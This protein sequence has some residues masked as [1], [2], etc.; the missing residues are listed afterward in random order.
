MLVPFLVPWLPWAKDY[1]PRSQQDCPHATPLFEHSTDALR[2]LHGNHGCFLPKYNWGSRMHCP[3]HVCFKHLTPNICHHK[4]HWTVTTLQLFSSTP[5]G[6]HFPWCPCE[7]PVTGANTVLHFQ[8]GMWPDWPSFAWGTVP[9]FMR[10][11]S[12]IYR[13]AFHNLLSL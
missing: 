12:F 6:E 2:K 10:M 3:S 13:K 11:Q 4:P 9:W 7:R 5:K 1:H 8:E